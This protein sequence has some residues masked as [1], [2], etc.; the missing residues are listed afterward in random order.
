MKRAALTPLPTDS[1]PFRRSRERFIP[2]VAGCYIL[3]T[4]EEDI[5]YI[6]LTGNLRRR[7]NEHLD[8]PEKTKLTQQGR[9]VMVYW[10][11]SE[12][13][14]KIERTW[15]NIYLLSEGVLPKLNHMYSPTST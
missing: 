13:I 15:M 7:I 12:E 3:T 14:N 1:E 6:G 10:T 5:L 4:F 9:A 2:S 8:N 11:V